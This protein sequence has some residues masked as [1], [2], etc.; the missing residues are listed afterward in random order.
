MYL[1]ESW[2]CNDL[3]MSDFNAEWG[4]AYQN[5]KR[6]RYE[7]KNSPAP[8][9][10]TCRWMRIFDIQWRANA[11]GDVYYWAEVTD[12]LTCMEYGLYC[13]WPNWTDLSHSSSAT[14]RGGYKIVRDKCDKCDC[15]KWPKNQW[16][17]EYILGGD[18]PPWE[19]GY[20]LLYTSDAADE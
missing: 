17:D 12:T 16:D 20:C 11:A 9:T 18:T 5:A 3:V 10:C 8:P 13:T 1:L 4:E 19:R 7:R 2:N 6:D 15:N 14:D